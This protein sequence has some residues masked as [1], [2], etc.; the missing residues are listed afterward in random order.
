MPYSHLTN[1]VTSD[2]NLRQEDIESLR[3]NVAVRDGDDLI[4]ISLPE[5]EDD[6]RISVNINASGEEE[7]EELNEE[8]TDASEESGVDEDAGEADVPEFHQ[9]DPKSL[10]EAS[11]VLAE[12]T[13]GHKEIIAEAMSKGL[14][15]EQVAQFQ[16]EYD[17]GGL[18][19]ASYESLQAL[20]YSKSFVNSF[21]AGQQS[22]ADNFVRELVGYCGGEDSFDKL[23]AFI[24]ANQPDTAKAFNAAVE[25]NDVTTIK[26]LLDSAKGQM[27]QSFGKQPKR[28]L[29]AQ[30]KPSNVV[31]APTQVEGFAS[32]AEMVKAMSDK[33][34]ERDA[35]Y[36]REVELK[37]FHA[38]F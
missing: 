18:S 16:T 4:E 9:V 12:A 30:A 5:E 37:V 29:A 23:T 28:N 19:D 3:Q 21:M 14:T 11:E 20:G 24:G 6:G 1:A 36:R 15:Q 38:Q 7:D 17:A 26:A 13:E 33:R 22:V 34:Y 10:E 32:R 2:A 27:R 35:A 31:K 25:R 8:G